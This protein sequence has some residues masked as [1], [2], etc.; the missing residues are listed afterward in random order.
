[1]N[2]STQDNRIREAF[3]QNPLSEEAK[4]RM[5]QNILR[6][7]EEAKSNDSAEPNTGEMPEIGENQTKFEEVR[8]EPDKKAK[9]R[10]AWRKYASI[11][12][13]PR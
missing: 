4:D 6:K 2:E 12:A 7:A 9:K 3:E 8:I 1:M 11:A 13:L 5:Y 10:Y